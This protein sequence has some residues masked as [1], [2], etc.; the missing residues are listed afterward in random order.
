MQQ[1]QISAYMQKAGAKRGSGSIILSAGAT[2]VHHCKVVLLDGSE[3]LL[4]VTN[5]SLFS[6]YYYDSRGFKGGGCS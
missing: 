5:V 2:K 4:E 6:F 3:L 1:D